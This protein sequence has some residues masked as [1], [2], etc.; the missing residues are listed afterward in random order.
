MVSS[1]GTAFGG[2]K[3]A[4]TNA[5]TPSAASLYGEQLEP[6]TRTSK[7]LAETV[8]Q[9]LTSG[10]PLGDAEKEA[11]RELILSLQMEG[12]FARL[13]A[14][15]PVPNLI[16]NGDF[17][18]GLE[19]PAFW[20]S[21]TSRNAKAVWDAEE[22]YW[23]RASG[24]VDASQ[25][26]SASWAQEVRLQPEC[27]NVLVSAFIKANESGAITIT[28][29]F[30]Q[31]SPDGLKL[32][33]EPKPA[34]QFAA[35][36]ERWFTC[37]WQLCQRE[38]PVPPGSTQLRLVMTCSDHG[39]AWFDNVSVYSWQ[40]ESEKEKEVAEMVN[41]EG[42]VYDA[43][44]KRPVEAAN[45]TI[46][47]VGAMSTGRDEGEKFHT[48]TNG[49]G[50]FEFRGDGV[51]SK[52][53][54]LVVSHPQYGERY[55]PFDAEKPRG[56][57]L[58]LEPCGTATLRGAV[59]INGAPFA[60]TFSVHVWGP[61]ENRTQEFH[62][63]TYR[64]ENMSNGDINVILQAQ[65]IPRQEPAKL[66]L[67]EG[68]EAVQDFYITLPEDYKPEVYLSGTVFDAET[69]AP[70]SG[71]QIAL[72][73][74]FSHGVCVSDAAGRFQTS[75]PMVREAPSIVMFVRRQGYLDTRALVDVSGDLHGD[76]E[77]MTLWLVAR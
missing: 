9:M 68:E 26:G 18:I 17:E 20:K 59:Y 13:V 62:A 19:T 7:E 52:T 61:G 24:C 16:R 33:S 39:K 10:R 15:H 37:D 29:Q 45:V 30:L 6:S 41:P 77:D 73:A 35:A 36:P 38:I 70:V 47:P 8:Y 11:L 5:A 74:S 66:R 25:G 46:D 22:R 40:P 34:I 63:S 4:D 49:V 1:N 32:V 42:Y 75:E 67:R 64:F 12:D 58:F 69:S 31:D 21:Q 76:I 2:N 57:E 60:G 44:T 55:F 72:D 23:G 48:V 28:P 50:H 3:D 65:G 54:Y 43:T 71:A 51:P 14:E 53:T 27:Q 56:L